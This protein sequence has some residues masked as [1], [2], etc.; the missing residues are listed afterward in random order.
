MPNT[1]HIENVAGSDIGELQPQDSSSLVASQPTTLESSSLHAIH[2]IPGRRRVLWVAL[3]LAT[4]VIAC[5]AYMRPWTEGVTA[6]VVENVTSGPHRRVLAVNGR[7]AATHSVDVR[8]P[9]AGTLTDAMAEEGQWLERG[10]TLARVDDT[11]QQAVVR[12][13]VAALDLGIVA[14][15]QAQ[16][17]LTRATALGV[18]IARSTQEDALRALEQAQREVGRLQAL[19]DQAQYQLTR[20]NIT[21]PITGTVLTRTAEPGQVIDQSTPL[22]TIAD[23][24]ELV[25]E[26]DVDE[27]YATQIRPQMPATLRLVGESDTLSGEVYFVAPVVD[28]ATGGLD[29][30]IRFS[31]P[32]QLPVGLTVTANITVDQKD[33][34]ISAPRSAIVSNDE[35]SMVFLFD[36]GFARQ[37]AVTVLDWPA[38]RL[39]VTE[40]L[41]A[42]DQL[43]TD[44]NG[45]S[46][47]QRVRLQED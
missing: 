24:S 31:K 15:Q 47:G 18:N 34:A 27:V 30:K 8:S 16:A 19:Y 32:R 22:F 6:V 13:A 17:A 3:I 41:K 35:G 28:P 2:P 38:E 33:S 12:Q 39:L 42:D 36:S 46:D 23:L 7:V 14:Q 37:A 5:L 45:L 1:P 20:F 25:V 21:A 26:T 9:V 10:A 43:I 40:G 11:P 4:I 44:A 29:V